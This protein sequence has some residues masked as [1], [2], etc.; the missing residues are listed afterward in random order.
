MRGEWESEPSEATLV[1]RSRPV[2]DVSTLAMLESHDAPRVHWASPDGLELVGAGTAARI[3]AQGP[4]RFRDLRADASRLFADVDHDGPP[5]TRPRL[6]GGLSFDADHRPDEPWQDFPA[7]AF[8]LPAIQLTRCDR[9]TYLTA[10]SYSA[11]PSAVESRLA[12]AAEQ[13]ERL[14]AMSPSGDPPGVTDSRWVTPRE[15]W[16][17]QVSAVRDRIRA[18]SL[19]KVVL[20]TALAVDLDGPVS[21]PAV[22]ER[23]RRSYP[24]CYR[25]LVQPG[26]TAFFGPPPEQLVRLDGRTVQ[27]EALAGSRPRGETPEKDAQLARELTTDEKTTGEQALVTET[28]TDQL[29]SFGSVTT[30]ERSVRKLATIQHLHTPIEAQLDDDHHVLELVERLHPTPA[31]GGLPLSDA[32]A[33]IRD[34]ESFDRGWYA[35]PV[36]WFDA[37]GDGEFAVGIRSGVADGASVTLFAGN[38]IVADSDPTAEWAELQPKVRPILDELARGEPRLSE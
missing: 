20:A 21:V 26:E 6:V 28:I 3:T 18:G 11:D 7:A 13:L 33:T 14:P 8:V 34:T 31:V 23:L 16:I 30:A 35:S 38:G 10:T 22:L 24:D 15:T 37:A 1:S 5:A 27:T 32:L 25:F 29:A 2:S 9:E 4:D 36:G 19:R 12:A 17:D